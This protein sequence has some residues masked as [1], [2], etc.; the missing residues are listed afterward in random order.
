MTDYAEYQESFVRIYKCCK[1]TKFRDFQYRL[2]LGKLV[3]NKDLY[4]WGAASSDK[5]TFCKTS[6]KMLE[7]ILIGCEKI[8]STTELICTMY[9]AINGSEM[10]WQSY[11][12]NKIDPED[13]SVINFICIVTKQFLY[14]CCCNGKTPQS[15]FFK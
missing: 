5:C 2:L 12:L 6:P 13:K 10:P 3:T 14:R 15:V 7:H 1:V 4:D 11:L 9:A 8:R